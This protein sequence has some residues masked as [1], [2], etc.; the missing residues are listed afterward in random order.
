MRRRTALDSIQ[1]TITTSDWT[2]K[3][4]HWPES[5]STSPSG[6]HLTHS[7]AL[8][9]R[10][11]LDPETPEGIIL[12]SK[13]ADLIEWQVNLL[14]QA[15]KNQ[16][17]YHR[18]KT[19]ANVMILKEPGNH[20]IHRLRVIHL[21]EHD[22]NLLLAVKWRSLIR[23]A[24]DQELLNPGQF[25]AVP[26][27][28]AV[29]P[30]LIEEFQYEIVRASK[31]PLVHI[32]YDATA[33]YDRIIMSLASLSSRSYGQH[34]NLVLINAS[35]LKSARYLLKTML[36]MSSPAYQNS[37]VFPIY[38]SGQGSGNSPGLWCCISS[39]LFDIYAEKAHGAY[40][41]TPCGTIT[42]KVYM[43]GFVD[44][45]SGSTNDFL[46]PIL[47]PLPH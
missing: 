36:G 31:R 14:N 39:T 45:T 20:K 40:F 35:M 23:L 13:R 10:H 37:D 30:T 17:V 2:G 9:A 5:T 26:G 8:L 4:K 41:Q 27:R 15:I 29:M 33:C 1:D 44:D 24:T 43:I 12:E 47:Q 3:I 34:R 28:D 6:F 46:S 21:Y 42:T 7:K 11:D 18:W 19:I 32:D 38:G 25:G 22:Y 16:H